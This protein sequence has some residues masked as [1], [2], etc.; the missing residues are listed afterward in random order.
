VEKIRVEFRVNNETVSLLVRP[1]ETLLE[2]LREQLELRSVKE[3][4][5]LGGCGCCTVL[6]DNRPIRSCLILTAGA[7]GASITTIEG[8]SQGNE[9]HPL[10]EAFIESGAVQCGF[11][12]PGMILTLKSLLDRSP[13]PTKEEIVKTLSS[14]LCRCTGYVKMIEAVKAATKG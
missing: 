5:G 14:N 3:A 11:C 9:L 1:Y 2:T 8:L 13:T 4:C 10:Q 12:T 6:F 7:E